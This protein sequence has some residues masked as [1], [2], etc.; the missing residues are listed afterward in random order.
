MTKIEWADSDVGAV[1]KNLI[2]GIQKLLVSTGCWICWR[3][4]GNGCWWIPVFYNLDSTKLPPLVSW[5]ASNVFQTLHRLSVHRYPYWW[6]NIPLECLSSTFDI[7]I[8]NNK[9]SQYCVQENQDKET[10]RSYVSAQKYLFLCPKITIV[11]EN[12]TDLSVYGN[13]VF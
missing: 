7:T 9:I 5:W 2:V 11:K 10:L 8:P 13:M 6:I 3:R 12:D 1:A 4:S